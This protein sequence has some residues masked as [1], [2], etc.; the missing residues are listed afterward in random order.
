M[1]APPLV[2]GLDWVDCRD[3]LANARWFRA[4]LVSRGV[5]MATGSDVA[6]SFAA[7]EEYG[8]IV[9]GEAPSRGPRARAAQILGDGIGWDILIRALHQAGPKLWSQ[10][11]G[12]MKELFGSKDVLFT[13]TAPKRTPARDLVLE[14]FTAGACMGFCSSV[15]KAEPDVVGVFNGEARSF[16]CK[17]FYSFKREQHEDRLVEGAK[18]VQR[19]PAVRGY[20]LVNLAPIFPHERFFPPRGPAP[21]ATPD[22][23]KQ[24]MEK[25]GARFAQRLFSK[26]AFGSRL[27]IDSHSGAVRDHLRG[28]I[29]VLPTIA[30]VA[31][32]ASR[33]F[34]LQIVPMPNNDSKDHEFELALHR[35]F[36]DVARHRIA[37]L[38]SF[39]ESAQ[40]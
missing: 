24:T 29:F 12:Q 28:I 22:Q 39:A 35:S 3:A 17:T 26:A 19:E 10:F 36:Q 13:R 4:F 2:P 31:G 34:W 30:D 11:D 25:L 1:D 23:F 7:Y 33:V 9:N 32:E 16:A 37:P 18:Q 14:L 8:R 38:D 5:T 6:V 27:R 15:E 40:P 20:V 21:F